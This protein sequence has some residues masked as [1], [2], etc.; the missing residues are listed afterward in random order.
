MYFSPL[1]TFPHRVL[2][3]KHLLM[4]NGPMGKDCHL[5][6]SNVFLKTTRMENN[7]KWQ[8][9][10]KVFPIRVR[11]IMP[12][13]SSCCHRNKRVWDFKGLLYFEWMLHL[14][15]SKKGDDKEVLV[16]KGFWEIITR[17][18]KWCHVIGMFRLLCAR[19]CACVPEY[20]KLLAQTKLK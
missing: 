5:R 19:F 14:Q 12:L 1:V 10:K 4:R 11:Q 3:I 15:G 13:S 20:R 6:V 16:E 18:S 17:K 8:K 2:L 9:E 7:D